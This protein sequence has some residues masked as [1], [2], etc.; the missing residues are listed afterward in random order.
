MEIMVDISLKQKK[1]KYIKSKWGDI[2]SP[3]TNIKK[4]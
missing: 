4:S 3:L 2:I 1:D